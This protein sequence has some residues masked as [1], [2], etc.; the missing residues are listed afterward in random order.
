MNAI[1]II[2]NAYVE[3]PKKLINNLTQTISYKRAA[4]P[5]IPATRRT[6]FTVGL[7]TSK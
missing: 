3:E 5:E 6:L 2:E 7:S 1:N 4:I